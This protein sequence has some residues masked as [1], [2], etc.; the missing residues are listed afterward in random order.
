MRRWFRFDINRRMDYSTTPGQSVEIRLGPFMFY[1][2]TADG[3][4]IVFGIRLGPIDATWA[5]QSHEES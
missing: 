2:T 3:W 4:S 1:V 5:A